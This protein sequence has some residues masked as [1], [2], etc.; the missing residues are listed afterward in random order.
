MYRGRPHWDTSTRTVSNCHDAIRAHRR[1]RG[2]AIHDFQFFPTSPLPFFDPLHQRNLGIAFIKN[3]GPSP[4]NKPPFFSRERTRVNPREQERTNPMKLINK[5]IAFITRPKPLQP[6][7]CSSSSTNEPRF[8]PIPAKPCATGASGKQ[9]PRPSRSALVLPPIAGVVK[10]PRGFQPEFRGG[11]AELLA[12]G[13]FGIGLV[14]VNDSAF[15]IEP[16]V[17]PQDR[18]LATRIAELPS[19]VKMTSARNLAAGLDLS[20]E[21]LEGAPR[22]RAAI[23]AV[24]S[25]APTLKETRARE[26]IELAIARRIGVHVILVGSRSQAEEVLM[27]LTTKNVL[28]FGSFR[29]ANSTGEL[30]D[31]LRLSLDGLLPAFGMRGTNTAILLVDCSDAMIGLFGGAT[32][33]GTVSAA[34][35]E[36]VKNPLARPTPKRL[37]A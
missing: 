32:R 3:L 2:D 33:V 15:V 26:L 7:G 23:V 19:R 12:D 14:G 18:I 21:I 11:A 22:G 9:I 31:A 34:L 4:R 8:I 29:V 6:I 37:A 1:Y 30:L 24:V 10:K 17:H 5:L 25:G 36:Y 16:P 20:L 27:G 28:G 13:Y 35:L